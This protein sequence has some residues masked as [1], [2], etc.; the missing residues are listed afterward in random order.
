[1]KSLEDKV[2]TR[3]DESPLSNDIK[4]MMERLD[5]IESDFKLQESGNYERIQSIKRHNITEWG[6]VNTITLNKQ[7]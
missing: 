3:D 2:N 1:M 5:V 4:T 6:K 7:I